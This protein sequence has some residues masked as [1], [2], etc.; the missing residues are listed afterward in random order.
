MEEELLV[1]GEAKMDQDGGSTTFMLVGGG[2]GGHL[3]PLL[4]VATA[5]KD[6]SPD[7]SVVVVGQK[8]E[9]L[10]EVVDH[11]S[12]DGVFSIS[13]GKFR[14]YNGE[15]LSSHLLDVRTLV[16]NVRD[17]FRFA[18]GIFE[19]WRLLGRIK[20]DGIFLKG[21]FVSVPI[22]LAA[23]W[24]R[25][26]YITHDSD[27][28]PGLANRITAKHAT[29]NAT[30]LPAD[31]YPYDKS[32]T[33]QVGIPLRK[34]FS[35]VSNDDL[36]GF[37]KQLSINVSDPVLLCLGGGLGA[38]GLNRALV[39]ISAELLLK[40]PDLE[41]VHLS[42]KSLFEETKKLYH[43]ALNEVSYNRVR[44]IDFTAD[45]YV[46]SGAADVIVSRAGATS[47][48]E[49]AVQSKPCV[50]VPNPVLTGGQQLHNAKVLQDNNAAM[51][52]E[53]N[54]PDELK[55]ALYSLLDDVKK[56][57]E[58]SNNLHKLSY[59]DSAERITG[60]LLS[61]VNHRTQKGRS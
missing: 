27:A 15:S 7:A 45:L 14:R 42:G 57:E 55:N 17:L 18:V 25:I 43:N 30:A 19:A 52:V 50:V 8:N 13:A 5:L 16:L 3:T 33:V 39:S 40:Y 26:P 29:Y 47:I 2:S 9:N 56:R 22:G 23:R 24:R 61:I 35:Y 41:M 44:V 49:F 34:E 37:K 58:L 60:L 11:D 59:K 21:G 46:L 10:Q 20:P 6:K 32:K 28:V 4:A 12:I 48:A 54:S 53:E 31:F 36:A 51:I 38:R 1:G